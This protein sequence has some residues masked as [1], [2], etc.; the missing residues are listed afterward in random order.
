LFLKYWYSNASAKK[1]IAQNSVIQNIILIKQFIEYHRSLHSII[2]TNLNLCDVHLLLLICTY[3]GVLASVCVYHRK[4]KFLPPIYAKPAISLKQRNEEWMTR[5]S[6]NIQRAV[7][8][9]GNHS[10]NN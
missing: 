4:N 1:T 10:D 9:L 3:V 7:G 6:V 8:R 2:K 5:M